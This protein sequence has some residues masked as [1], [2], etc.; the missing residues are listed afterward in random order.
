VLRADVQ[1]T[2]GRSQAKLARL[3]LVEDT[4]DVIR[5]REVLLGPLDL[6][7]LVAPDADSMEEFRGWLPAASEDESERGFYLRCDVLRTDINELSQMN[8]D[9]WPGR[10]VHLAGPARSRVDTPDLR[11]QIPPS[12]D[13]DQ[14]NESPGLLSTCWDICWAV[15]RDIANR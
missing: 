6:A 10:N 8:P 5:R 14:T 11:E 3:E 12:A 4:D 13:G 2:P 1:A 7:R 9:E 15:D